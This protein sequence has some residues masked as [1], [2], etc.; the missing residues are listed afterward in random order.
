MKLKIYIYRINIITMKVS[1]S[2]N[3]IYIIYFI[4]FILSQFDIA[5]SSNNIISNIDSNV[6]NMYQQNGKL[7]SRVDKFTVDEFI[8]DFLNRHNINDCFSFEDNNVLQ[9]KCLRN[10]KLTN[11]FLIID[12]NTENTETIV[13]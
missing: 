2:N 13:V 4:I 5:N 3:I 7:Y 8:T 1:L 6:E 12:V 10:N 11:V 9:L